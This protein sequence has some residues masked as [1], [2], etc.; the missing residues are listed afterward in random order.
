MAR[1]QLRTSLLG[2]P[3]RLSGTIS[4]SG[5][6][7][8]T[9]NLTGA[10]TAS[11]T[12][13]TSGVYSFTGLV[14]GSYTVTPTKS[15]FVMTPANRAVTISGANATANFT[16]AQ[17]FTLSGTISGSGGSGATVN[18]TGA[19]TAS[20]TANTSGV[21]SFTGLVNGSY[22]VTP[23][24]SGFAMTPTNR[25]VTI[26]GANATANFTSAQTF[27]L[28][29]TISGSGGS[30]ATVNLTG[31][32]TASTT[33][34]T[35]GVYSFTGLVNG[36]YTVTPTKS[37]FAMTPVNRAVTISGA[38][39]TANFTSAQTFT[40]SGTISGSGG[41]L[42]T[43]NLT[44][45]KTASTTANIF[46]QYSFTGLVNGSYTVTPT[47]SGF[48]M[49]PVNRAVTISGANATANFTSAVQTATLGSTP[50][51]TGNGSVSLQLSTLDVELQPGQTSPVTVQVTP[52]NGF[53]QTVNL[54]CQKLPANVNCSFEPASLLVANSQASTTMNV[55]SSNAASI[56]APRV[57]LSG[58][59]YGAML[60]WN[61][62]G[63]LATAAARKRKKLGVLRTLMLLVL[64][65]VGAMAMSGC[66]V[67]YNT[68]AQ[69]YHVT[70]TATAN[71]ATVN[72]TTFVVV[73][74][75]KAELL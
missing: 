69:T 8:A 62:I 39:A 18:L 5:G 25:A 3:L 59:S 33:A 23:T 68:V 16:S 48:A 64:T 50:T 15:G 32:K 56:A 36:S 34:N 4:G 21:Y 74:R 12:A 41:S 37:G 55:S 54:D 53:S 43:V 70:L 58:I 35:S 42:A 26:S 46:G 24:K 10:K 52:K 47:K 73:L 45:A 71:G 72:S 40:L 66:G 38:N 6:S 9:V 61:L 67:T 60:P 19:K 28:S 31:A 65:G 44:G 22:T 14:N 49:T 20:T 1:T 57:G 2:R 17:T 7:G 29:G 51:P 13:N 30:G 63:M 11:T 27:T 75:E